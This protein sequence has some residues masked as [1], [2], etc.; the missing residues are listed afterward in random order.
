MAE[1]ITITAAE[2]DL[3]YHRIMIHLSGIDRVWLAARHKDYEEADRLGRQV[4]DE[5]HLLLDDL[6]WGETRGE[7]PVELTSP[8]Q[9]VRRVVEFLREQARAEDTDER[10]DREAMR[11][12]EE[13][14]REVR[15]VC[16]G[17][18]DQLGQA[19][20]VKGGPTGA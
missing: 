7:Q 3:L 13:E 4:C 17:V 10:K 6:G 20:A 12:A 19:P 5:L 9:V 18:L 8:P 11:S 15:A 1:P 16:D 14:N 2:R